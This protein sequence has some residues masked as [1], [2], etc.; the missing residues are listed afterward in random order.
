[1]LLAGLGLITVLLGVVVV[2]AVPWRPHPG[3]Q[4]L[5]AAAIF[6]VAVGLLWMGGLLLPPGG[7]Y[8]VVTFCFATLGFLR[9][10]QEPQPPL[11]PF[12]FSGILGAAVYHVSM[13]VLDLAL[14]TQVFASDLELLRAGWER[15][16]S[17]VAVLQT[18]GLATPMVVGGCVGHW[19]GRHQ[20]R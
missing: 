16:L 4:L 5:D 13:S 15:S 20:C 6:S 10:R 11:L 3:V 14:S 19:I 18:V 17:P 12:V 2:A 9:A 8:L 1:M 7:S